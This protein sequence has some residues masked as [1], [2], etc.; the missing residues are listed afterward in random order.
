MEV[1]I[2]VHVVPGEDVSSI[3]RSDSRPRRC[4]ARLLVLI[5]LEGVQEPEPI[6]VAIA[7][8]REEA[9]PSKV[10]EPVHVELAG[11]EVF[12]PGRL[13]VIVLSMS[14]RPGG[15]TVVEVPR[16]TW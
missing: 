7:R 6:E 12:L 5:D 3:A 14:W 1:N 9:V 15:G 4:L 8:T 11:E 2:L 13:V 10:V 16:R